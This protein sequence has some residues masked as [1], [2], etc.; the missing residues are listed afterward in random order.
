ML[1]KKKGSREL[2]HLESPA[3][4]Y[5]L[6]FPPGKIASLMAQWVKNPPAVQ[7]TQGTPRFDPRVEKIPRRRAW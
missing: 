4:V 7:E 5:L 1:E 3:R 2:G 6:A